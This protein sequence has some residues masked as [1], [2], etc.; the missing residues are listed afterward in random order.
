M[1]DNA[2]P[3]KRT[4][5][6]LTSHNM[7]GTSQKHPLTL[8]RLN[9]AETVKVLVGLDPPQEFAVCVG[10]IAERSGLFRAHQSRTK[11]KSEPVVLCNYTPET[12]DMYLHCL[13]H[14]KVPE[15]IPPPDE[16]EKTATSHEGDEAYWER[17]TDS[18]FKSLISL[19]ALANK[20]VD[21]ITANMVI[22]QIKGSNHYSRAPGP[23][24]M[25]LA[26]SSTTADSKLRNLLADLYI[27]NMRATHGYRGD[28]PKAF[29]DLFLKRFLDGKG[30]GDIVINGKISTRVH[31]SHE[32]Y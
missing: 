25:E 16:Y 4:K 32:Y 5:Y 2:P 17:Y 30:S 20:L 15:Y 18:K 13:Y 22:D 28:Y 6:L 7:L 1:A 10:I 11:D 19:Y 29:L 31:S 27:S 24:V 9:F 21:R 23:E 14:K 3:A 26:F 12:F 8:Y